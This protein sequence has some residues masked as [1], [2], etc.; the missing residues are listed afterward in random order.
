MNGA[1]TLYRRWEELLEATNTAEDEEFKWT[2]NE[3][4][5]V[6]KSIEWD[7]MDLEETINILFI[8]LVCV[9]ECVSAGLSCRHACVRVCIPESRIWGV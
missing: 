5:R 9:R 2:T 6:I 4:K 8:L 1:R 7:L 3:L